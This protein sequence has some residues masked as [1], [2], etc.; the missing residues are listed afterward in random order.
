MAKQSTLKL[1]GCRV[2]WLLCFLTVIFRLLVC[3]AQ[4]QADEWYEV[5]MDGK[6]DLE[7]GD[8]QKAIKNF[9]KA[10][11]NK[12]K[13]EAQA[14][15]SG[16]R[17]VDYLPYYYQGQAYLYSGKYKSALESFQN[18]LSS[19]AVNKTVH[20]RHIE[21]LKEIVERMIRL[22]DEQVSKNE[23]DVEF[24]RRVTRLQNFI[25]NE[26][27]NEASILLERLKSDRPEDNRIPI[28]EGWIQNGPQRP[29][30]GSTSPAEDLVDKGLEYYIIGQYELALNEFKA[31][32]KSDPNFSKAKSWIRK[33]QNE[34]RR[35]I[36]Q[37][38]D[39]KKASMENVPEPVIIEKIITQTI[40]PVFAIRAPAEAF[41]ETRSDYL[42]LSGQAGDDQGIEYIELTVN[43][44]PGID[45]SGE[46]V[47]IRPGVTDDPKKFS[48][49]TDIPLQMGEN[50]IV[51]IA[52]DMDLTRHQSTELFTVIR[53][54]PIY[55]TPAFGVS[56]GAIFLLGLGGFFISGRIKYRIA[57]V[58]KYNPYIAGA[59]IRNEEM[60]FGREKLVKR[61]LNIIHNNSLMVHGQRRIGKTSLQHHLKHRLETLQDS[62]FHFIPVMID[63]QGTSEERLFKTLME[64]ILEVCKPRLN[65]DV[66]FKID[67]DKDK[68]SVRDFS[69]DLN[70]LLDIL[71]ED[72]KKKLKLVLLIDEVDQMNTYSEQINQGLRSV[73]MQTFAEN[74]AAIMSGSYIK[75]TWESEGSPWF[76]FFEELEVTPFEHEDAVNL[77]KRPVAGIF[78]YDD[79]AI[80]G[81]INY[82]E[83][84]PYIIQKLCVHLINHIIEQKRRRVTTRDVEIVRELAL[85]PTNVEAAIPVGS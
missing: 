22:S 75:K 84:K 39:S 28:I 24:E 77:I 15:T 56:V 74:L 76:N 32:E 53:K 83:C 40:A 17:M 41:T 29:S 65:N 85:S 67:Q 31:A 81:I 5:Y 44:E 23:S 7:R 8:W 3:T 9:Q 33:T 72:T 36:P 42:E 69:R 1:S 48:F 50:Q 57:I 49:S 51:L 10:L 82:S 21:K 43:G 45:L 16:L 58:N 26:N 47:K 71:R 68:Y 54:S 59:P 30:E 73:F 4:L 64:E 11:R 66:S 80:E 14:A 38:D 13:P 63:L 12:S 35:V 18:S 60:F 79:E 34:M 55:Q 27:Y 70:S 6:T 78:S 61:I 20:R 37:D 19:G 46:K 52:Y 62:E 2:T 25:S